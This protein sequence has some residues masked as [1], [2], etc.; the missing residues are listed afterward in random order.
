MASCPSPAPCRRA[1]TSLR[2]VSLLWW[3]ARPAD[4]LYAAAS[5]G[6][7]DALVEFALLCIKEERSRPG[8]AAL[9]IRFAATA[10]AAPRSPRRR[11]CRSG[12]PLRLRP[13]LVQMSDQQ[14][15]AIDLTVDVGSPVGDLV[16]AQ[17]AS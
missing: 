1:N 2:A 13:R 8:G 15:D 17:D 10:L 7:E 3:E 16:R 5:G 12:R 9:P 11:L 14:H 4:R 6:D